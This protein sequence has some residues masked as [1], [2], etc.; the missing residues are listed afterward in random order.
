MNDIKYHS[1]NI[2]LCLKNIGKRLKE[3]IS[4]SEPLQFMETDVTKVKKFVT[5]IVSQIR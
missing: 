2:L 1:K 4:I 5:E 3:K